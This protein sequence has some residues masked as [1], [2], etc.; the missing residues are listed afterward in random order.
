MN[1]KHGK[2]ADLLSD[3]PV[4]VTH[5]APT[6]VATT[7]S[8]IEVPTNAT[9]TAIS[10]IKASTSIATTVSSFADSSTSI[11][12]DLSH[13]ASTSSA[14]I[15]LT[16]EEPKLKRRRIKHDA[17]FKAEVIQKKEERMHTSELI[18]VYKSFN[19]DKTNTSK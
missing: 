7:I 4:S 8:S 2:F 11:A 14:V 5:E 10:S 17:L 3:T 12:T 15:V 1:F 16:S 9:G 18:T 13:E 19:L 6:S